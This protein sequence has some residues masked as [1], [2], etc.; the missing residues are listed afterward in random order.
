MAYN[1]L[2]LGAVADLETETVN[3]TPNFNRKMKDNTTTNV[4]LDNGSP[5]FANAMLAAV[6]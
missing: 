6:R 5:A 1:V 4:Q 3:L 2:A